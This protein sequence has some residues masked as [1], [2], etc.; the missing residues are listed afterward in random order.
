M[1]VMKHTNFI[2]LKLIDSNQDNNSNSSQSPSE[3]I[4]SLG[5]LSLRNI[6]G[7]HSIKANMRMNHNRCSNE[8]V[9]YWSA[10]T[11]YKGS[12]DEGDQREGESSF[13][14]PVIGSVRFMRYENFDWIINCSFDNLCNIDVRI[15]SICLSWGKVRGPAGRILAGLEL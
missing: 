13:E 12:Y 8:G 11:C 9:K 14:C 2:D 15:N 1:T 7:N 3:N 6:I 10:G 4:I 5:I